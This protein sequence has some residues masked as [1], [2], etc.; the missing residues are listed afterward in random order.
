MDR[1]AFQF[2]FYNHTN[3]IITQLINHVWGNYHQQLSSVGINLVFFCFRLDNNSKK[4]SVKASIHHLD[5]IWSLH[6]FNESQII[7]ILNLILKC[8]VLLL[9]TNG[10]NDDWMTMILIL[11]WMVWC[12]VENRDE[13]KRGYDE[14]NHDDQM[15]HVAADRMML[16]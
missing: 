2:M 8:A 4:W 10:D 3:C 11:L 7:L 6:S 5:N 16:V 15:D 1:I 12:V 9:L 14:K 13:K